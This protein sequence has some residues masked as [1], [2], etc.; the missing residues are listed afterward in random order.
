MVAF[1]ETSALQ[2]APRPMNFLPAP[3]HRQVILAVVLVSGCAE[4]SPRPQPQVAFDKTAWTHAPPWA[5]AS[6]SQSWWTSYGDSGL[7]KRIAA[8]L[9]GN[10]E[11]DILA[12]RLAKAEAQSRQAQAAGWPSIN[13]G[14]RYREGREQQRD[15]GFRPIDLE[16]W[17]G[18]AVMSWEID[19]SGKVRA[20]SRAADELRQAAF[21]E[22][23]A[24]RLKVATGVAEA[25]FRILR[26][27]DE[28]ALVR[29][30]VDAN[31]RILT[32]LRQR[33]GVGV[34][35]TTELRRQEGEHER[36]ERTLLDLE[37][38]QGLASLQLAT[39]MGSS[40]PATAGSRSL[41]SVSL[42]PLPT[43]AAGEVLRQRPDLLAAEA[44]VRSAFQVEESSRLALLP[45]ISLDAG[46]AGAT[47]SLTSR[48]TAWIATVGP[49]VDIPVWDPQ[50]LAQV[51]VNRATTDE[52]AAVYQAAALT[53][54][55]ETEAAYLNFSNRAR[56][57][58]AARREVS[59]LDEA[60]RN[61]LATFEA[62]IVSQIELLESERR[63]LEARRQELAV[64]HALLRDH[65]A[66][67]RALGG[68]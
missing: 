61:T 7:N 13:L 66:L 23:H 38:L 46:A 16:P 43:R 34:I 5:R 65:L 6:L 63:S 35:S 1:R 20:R 18:S 42:P 32:T 11:L 52:A 51:Q 36:L 58:E 24:A 28:R 55:E 21:W 29:E 67:T 19:L 49:T 40:T 53:A 12:A 56:Q 39:L 15:T 26:L 33:A 59:A 10:P 37:R 25:H 3:L 50:R 64:Q 17:A 8:A 22:Y 27:R 48:F 14:G 45:S 30:S 62:G 68:A 2:R 47:S 41:Q 60:R 54:F 57:R 44:R 4:Y 31:Q 9:R